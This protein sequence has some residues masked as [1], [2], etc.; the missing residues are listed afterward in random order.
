MAKKIP[1]L[2]LWQKIVTI[3]KRRLISFNISTRKFT[4]KYPTVLQSLQVTVTYTVAILSLFY[5]LISMLGGVPGMLESVIPPTLEKFVNSPIYSLFF[6]PERA[7][8]IYLFTI[9][10]VIY[11]KMFQFSPIIKYHILLI[12]LL[13]MVQ[14]LLLSY[15]D[16]FFSGSMAGSA[17]DMTIGMI[18]LAL[19]FIVLFSSYFYGFFCAIRGKFAVFPHMNWLTNSVAIWLRIKKRNMGKDKQK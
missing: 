13:E 7:Y 11:R 2:S 17:L 16:L 18:F 14:N 1:Q 6:A 5:S 4:K 3:L 9:E 8:I 12:F 15:W 10:F 19:I